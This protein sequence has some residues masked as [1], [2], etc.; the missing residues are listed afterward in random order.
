MIQHMDGYLSGAQPSVDLF[1]DRRVNVRCKAM[2]RTFRARCISIIAAILLGGCA[3]NIRHVR[4]DVWVDCLSGIRCNLA[5]DRL[6]AGQCYDAEYRFDGISALEPRVV[7]YRAERVDGV[8][9]LR[10]PNGSTAAMTMHVP[11]LSVA[12]GNQ[13]TFEPRNEEW[14][15]IWL[16]DARS[17]I[18]IFSPPAYIDRCTLARTSETG[19]TM[20]FSPRMLWRG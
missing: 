2:T 5:P 20:E 10:L 4:Q 11:E 13:A 3:A 8:F 14:S 9:Y 6:R 12:I 15:A 18:P 19:K 17:W 1:L 16:R 7:S